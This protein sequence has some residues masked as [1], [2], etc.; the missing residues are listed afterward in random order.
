MLTQAPAQ[1]QA[2]LWCNKLK[3]KNIG[4]FQPVIIFGWSQLPCGRSQIG[5]MYAVLMWAMS[6]KILIVQPALMHTS[7]SHNGIYFGILSIVW[8]ICLQKKCL[9]FWGTFAGI[10]SILVNMDE[11]ILM[12][13]VFL[14][15][16][17][18]TEICKMEFL[19]I[20]LHS[21]KCLQYFSAFGSPHTGC[22]P[23]YWKY[24]SALCSMCQVSLL[25]SHHT[26]VHNFLHHLC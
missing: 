6:S 4:L 2:K 19:R 10:L 17:K 25:V 20:F 5:T 14:A 12:I 1:A 11:R 26:K 23:A 15:Q 13:L 9:V 3:L 21:Q 7:Y 8:V 18:H 22:I 16:C 24:I